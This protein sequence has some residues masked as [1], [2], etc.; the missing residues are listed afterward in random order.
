ME[1]CGIRFDKLRERERELIIIDLSSSW[2]YLQRQWKQRSV[3][4]LE[5]AF[6]HVSASSIEV[7]LRIIDGFLDDISVR[8]LCVL[9]SKHRW[10]NPT[11]AT[12]YPWRLWSVAAFRIVRFRLSY[13]HR[14][15][16]W[17]FVREI[18]RRRLR[19]ANHFRRS[20]FRHT[21]K[22]RKWEGKFSSRRSDF[23]LICFGFGQ[24][25][26]TVYSAVGEA[27][28]QQFSTTGNF[29]IATSTFE[30]ETYSPPRNFTR[31]FFRSRME[32]FVNE[33]REFCWVIAYR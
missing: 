3:Q 18:P 32:K 8:W 2:H 10:P 24:M 12:N 22:R 13:T 20:I 30:S 21:T 23:T 9:I 16:P 25:R 28:R 11:P 26:S 5:Q 27:H 1:E 6:E 4:I 31:S 29:V 15:H 19:F 33:D 7:S 14:E 17:E